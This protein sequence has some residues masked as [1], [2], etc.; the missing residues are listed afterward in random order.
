VNAGAPSAADI[1]SAGGI[2]AV[3]PARN[4]ARRVAATVAALKRIPGIDEV[5]VVDDGSTDDTAAEAERAG[6]RVIRMSRNEGKGRALEA[7]ARATNAAVVLLADADLEESASN[8]RVLLDPVVAGE[9]D[10]AIA[11]PPR[12]GGPSGFG[13]VEGFARWGTGMLTGRRFDRPLSGQRAVRAD[14]LKAA[15]RF[16]AGFGAE[17][18]FTIDAVRAGYRV[19]EVPCAISHARTGRDPAGFA[20]RAKQGIDVARALA[21]RWRRR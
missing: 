8:L 9:A 6:A 3:V 20:H 15:G 13:L 21:G 17:T 14:V 7:G 11:A 18:G 19:V 2:A 5:I 16:A 1:P 10:V 4:E 12:V